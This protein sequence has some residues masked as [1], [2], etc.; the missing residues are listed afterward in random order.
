MTG[1]MMLTRPSRRRLGRPP[2][3]PIAAATAT[4]TASSSSTSLNPPSGIA[5]LRKSSEHNLSQ[6]EPMNLDDF[7]FSENLNTP[8]PHP[9]AKPAAEEKS[10]AH[11]L[12]PAIPIKSRKDSAQQQQQQQPQHF[13]PQS[14]PFPPHHQRSHDEFNYVTRHHRKTS[15]DERRVSACLIWP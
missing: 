5:Q 15:I 7:I 11:S 4:A 1:T 13:V 9:A 12:T 10:S 3:T 2:P 6:S 14:V 8:S